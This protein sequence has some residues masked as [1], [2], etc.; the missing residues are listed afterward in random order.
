M[1]RKNL[2]AVGPDDRPSPPLSITEAARTGTALQLLQAMRDRVAAAVE[3][4]STP[5]RDLASLSKR[6]MEITR[7]IET[8]QARDE[9]EAARVTEASDGKFNAAAV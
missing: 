5:A 8:Q 4:E 1:P 9:E 2:R 7:E 3:D 6:L